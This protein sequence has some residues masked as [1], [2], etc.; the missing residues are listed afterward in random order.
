MTRSQRIKDYKKWRNCEIIV[1]L[2]NYFYEKYGDFDGSIRY[3]NLSK[4][5]CFN[6]DILNHIDR[7]NFTL[8]DFGNISKNP[9]FRIEWVDLHPEYMWNF[10]EISKSKYLCREWLEKYPE[11]NWNIDI[12]SRHEN[13]EMEWIEE[14]PHLNWRWDL[15]SQSKKL[16]EEWFKKYKNLINSLYVCACPNFKLEWIDKY[17]DFPWNWNFIC[18]NY[19]FTLKQVAYN[20]D[21][22][23][24]FYHVIYNDNLKL[25]WLKILNTKL[26]FI[27]WGTYDIYDHQNFNFKWIDCFTNWNWEWE[28]GISYNKYLDIDNEKMFEKY[29]NE[30]WNFQGLSRNVNLN[31]KFY[32]KYIDKKWDYNYLSE[33]PNLTSEWL[34]SNPNKNWDIEKLSSNPNFD[35]EWIDIFPDAIWNLKKIGRNP[36]MKEHWLNKK[37]AHQNPII[38]FWHPRGLFQEY[39]DK[40]IIRMDREYMAA[41]KIQ[42]WWVKLKYDPRSKIGK[43]FVSTLYDEDIV[44]KLFS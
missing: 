32:K 7:L 2:D 1:K 3:I 16:T 8:W 6:I 29:K 43:K 21:K 38:S 17:P 37:V 33:N 42:L 28:Y 26:D 30:K 4:M 31:F 24:C 13:F 22:G 36:N 40:D 14:F 20:I 10:Q 44:N 39:Y 41:Y 19:N 35:I 18:N 25:D 5:K 9:Y 15:I 11:K 27:Y 23:G 12:I 34:K